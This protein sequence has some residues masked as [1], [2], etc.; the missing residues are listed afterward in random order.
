MMTPKMVTMVGV[1][2]PLN[3]ESFGDTDIKTYCDGIGAYIALPTVHA[4][5]KA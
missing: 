2:T 1:K 4:T 5:G 3:V